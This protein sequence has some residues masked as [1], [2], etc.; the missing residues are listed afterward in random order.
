MKSH[1]G[2]ETQRCF[3]HPSAPLCLCVSVALC[4][5][6]L[7][8]GCRHFGTGGTGEIVVR[9]RVLRE[10]DAVDMSQYAVAPPPLATQP[11]TQALTQP[12]TRL[13]PPEERTIRVEEV[14]RLALRNNLDLRVE[15]VNP[16]IAKT[17]LTEEQ[18]RFEAL[19]TSNINFAK[20]DAATF[21]RL[22]A[23]QSENLNADVGVTVPLQTGGILKFDVPV[24][25]FKT[26]NE[27]SI[28]NPSYSSDF[29]ASL[30]QPL[31]RGAGFDVNANP[32]RLAFYDLQ[33]TEAR[34]KLEITRVLAEADR[35]YWRLYAAR[36]ELKVR[37][38]EYDLAVV[39]LERARRQVRA[40]QAAEVEIIRA[41]SGVADTLENIINAENAVRD[42][43]RD[44]KRVINEEGLGMETD[45]VLVPATE[46]NA[47]Y[48]KLPPDQ[49]AELALDRRMEM[50]DLELQIAAATANVDFARNG[51]LPLLA[52]QY[53]Y[54]INGLGGTFGQSFSQVDDTNFQ[55]HT[56]GLHLE[57]PLG[58]AAARA[59]LRRAI[60]DR[61]QRLATRE[62]RALQIRQEVYNAADQLEANWQRIVA[63]RQRTVLAARVL[64]AEIRQFEQGLRTSTEVLDAQT[65]L[66]NA[67]SAEISA[68]ADY[69]ISQINV[70]FAT[71]TLLGADNVIWSPTAQPKE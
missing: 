18:A 17:T 25:R 33:A 42:T 21:T 36:E 48:F 30:S 39:Q 37:K 62:Q 34:T 65:K 13:T 61:V 38:Q 58:N 41:E 19:F 55:D 16:S 57:V 26:N 60:L 69:Q 24:N 2:T 29:V 40:A 14:R 50:L 7:I 32:I 9:Q 20:N 23:S 10:I 8:V 12:S 6:C 49:L 47:L 28:L 53:T 44:L 66:A 27:F 15:L 11:S 70:A 5:C 68:V 54:S 4:F 67:R 59:R 31:L 45:T 35:V 63:A 51:T 3:R 22:D 1:S 43:Q 52:L 56:V 46:P 64:A 71:G